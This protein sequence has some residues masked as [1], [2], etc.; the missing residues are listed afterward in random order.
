MRM[1]K[2]R[3]GEAATFTGVRGGHA[4][5]PQS[6]K[7]VRLMPAEGLTPVYRIKC[8]VEPFERVAKETDLD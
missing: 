4:T 3:V 1:H 7:I 8:T 6:C 2:F 5:A